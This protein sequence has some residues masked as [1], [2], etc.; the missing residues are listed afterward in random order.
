MTADRKA[1]VVSKLRPPVPAPQAEITALVERCLL[2]VRDD[3]RDSPYIR[4]AL[5]VLPVGGYRSAIGSFWNAVVDDLRNKVIA[6]SIA[7]FSKTANVGRELKTYDDLQNHVTDDQLIEGAYRIGVIGWEA[8]KILRHA[9]ETRPCG[10]D[11]G[12]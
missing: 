2:S 9:K 5:R 1:I 11:S 8:S 12:C 3:I 10:F 4:E 7:I 6:R